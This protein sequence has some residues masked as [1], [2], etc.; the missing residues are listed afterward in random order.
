MLTRA[1][2]CFPI[3]SHYETWNSV[4]PSFKLHSYT[5]LPFF[6]WDIV[7]PGIKLLNN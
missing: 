5:C 1:L 2:L 7:I 6:N 4:I 3:N